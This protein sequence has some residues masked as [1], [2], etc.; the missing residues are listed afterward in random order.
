M[1]GPRHIYVGQRF[2]LPVLRRPWWCARLPGRYSLRVS[3][4]SLSPIRHSLEY[5][6]IW[7]PGCQP[8][9]CC[10]GWRR[11]YPPQYAC[12][13]YGNSPVDTNRLGAVGLS[14]ARSG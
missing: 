1:L 14:L 11:L 8:I 7:L 12:L 2:V 5:R 13:L 4:L 9:L 3:C 6:A 10:G